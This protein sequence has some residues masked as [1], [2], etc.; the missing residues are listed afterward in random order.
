MKTFVGIVSTVAVLAS[1][2][3]SDDQAV[4]QIAACAGRL[5][6]Q[7]EHEWLMRDAAVQETQALRQEMTA[8]LEGTVA[9][10]RVADVLNIRISAKAAQ[11]RLLSRATFNTD[12]VDAGRAARHAR[13]AIRACKRAFVLY[14]PNA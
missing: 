3:L 2:A 8:V 9:Q 11:A 7:V 6:A 12:A 10:D 1:P 4:H 5:S 14:R 13:N